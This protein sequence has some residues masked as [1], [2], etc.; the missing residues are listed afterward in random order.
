MHTYILNE[1]ESTFT[2]YANIVIVYLSS[3]LNLQK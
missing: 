2:G 3:N 1:T